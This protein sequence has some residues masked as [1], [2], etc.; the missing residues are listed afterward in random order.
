MDQTPESSSRG[1]IQEELSFEEAFDRLGETVQALESGSLTLE[2]ATNLYEDGMRLVKLCNRL[3]SEAELKVTQL[4]DVYS[5]R[6]AHKA[7][8]GFPRI[9]E[10]EIE[11]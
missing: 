3:L 7:L 11:E 6:P 2:S 9:E 8:D 5:E 1:E 4:K 10:E